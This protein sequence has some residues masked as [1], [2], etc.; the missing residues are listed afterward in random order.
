M[1]PDS[2]QI[3]ALALRVTNLEHAVEFAL[4]LIATIF[5]DLA[6]LA[7]RGSFRGLTP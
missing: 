7:L 2:L 1:S 5:F 4:T 3:A 6:R